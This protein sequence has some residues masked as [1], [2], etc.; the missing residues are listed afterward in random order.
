[1]REG[2]MGKKCQ[3]CFILTGF[4]RR[5]LQPKGFQCLCT[6]LHHHPLNTHTHT[7]TS[8]HREKGS[9]LLELKLRPHTA[10]AAPLS[11]RGSQRMPEP[12]SFPGRLETAGPGSG[13]SEGTINCPRCPL[14]PALP[15]PG[16]K[17]FLEQRRE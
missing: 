14:P 8:F 13:V 4:S 12:L 5:V 1:M 11:H 3:S 2:G 9:I 15:A 16:L 10:S 17:D 7:H 6:T